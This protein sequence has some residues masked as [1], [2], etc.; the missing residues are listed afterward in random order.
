MS[1]GTGVVFPSASGPVSVIGG[2]ESYSM[3][4]PFEVG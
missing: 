3:M 2:R 1:G 4:Y